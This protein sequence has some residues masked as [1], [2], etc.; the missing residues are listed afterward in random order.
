V[1]LAAHIAAH[2]TL[3]DSSICASGINGADG[4]KRERLF[5]LLA[6]AAFPAGGIPRR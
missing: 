4:S 2:E 5:V 3:A 1:N 6:G